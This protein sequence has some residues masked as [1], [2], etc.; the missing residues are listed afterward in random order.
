MKIVKLPADYVRYLNEGKH[1]V[2]NNYEYWVFLK[3]FH[4]DTWYTGCKRRHI[5]GGNIEE[6]KVV[7]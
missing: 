5:K 1:V 3:V 2:F 7:C 4:H 6:V